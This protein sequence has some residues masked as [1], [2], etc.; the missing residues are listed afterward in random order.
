MGFEVEIFPSSASVEKKTVEGNHVIRMA[1]T[2]PDSFHE[3][4]HAQISA[5]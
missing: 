1:R 4:R 3:V 5:L 2:V